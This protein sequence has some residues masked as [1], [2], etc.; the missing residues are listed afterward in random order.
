MKI[1]ELLSVGDNNVGGK[2]LVRKR[3]HTLVNLIQVEHVDERSK[4]ALGHFK[5]DKWKEMQK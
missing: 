2:A 3:T 4:I 5:L 1:R